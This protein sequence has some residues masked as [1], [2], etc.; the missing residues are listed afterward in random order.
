[1]KRIS[2]ICF[3]AFSF[4]LAFAGL[5]GLSQVSKKA[6]PVHA[7]DSLFW[8]GDHNL[9]ADPVANSEDGFIGEARLEQTETEYILHLSSFKNN[10]HYF[11]GGNTSMALRM[12]FLKKPVRI[13][14]AGSSILNNNS[15][16]FENAFGI[17]T[18]GDSGSAYDLIFESEDEDAPGEL[19]VN[20][21]T[22]TS[23][24]VGMSAQAQ[25]NIYFNH[26]RVEADGS[27]APK[28]TGIQTPKNIYVE[29]RARLSVYNEA[30]NAA[31][32][33]STNT[34]ISCGNFEMTSSTVYLE[35]GEARGGGMSAGMT[36]NGKFTMNSGSFTANSG[37]SEASAIGF[38]AKNDVVVN[39]GSFCAVG[40]HSGVAS[41]SYGL[42]TTDTSY[43][44]SINKGCE[45]FY[46]DSEYRASNM[47]ITSVLN[48]FGSLT[49]AVGLDPSPTKIP[50]GSASHTFMSIIFQRMTYAVECVDVDYNGKAHLPLS[51]TVS[52]PNTGYTIQ[53]RE[54]GTTA[55]HD[56]CPSFT[57]FKKGGYTI[58]Y[59]IEADYYLYSEVI[60]SVVFNI[61]K[62]NSVL[63]SAPKKVADFRA[64]GKEHALVSAGSAKGGTVMYS[65]N[66]GEYSAKVP[67]ASR[68]GKY[69]IKYK[70][71][72]DNNHNDIAEKSLGT[73]NVAMSGGAI[74][75]I[76][77]GSVV[78]AG[79]GGFALVWFVVL[80]KSW[81]ELVEGFK[82]IPGLF[83][84][85]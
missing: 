45:M 63:Q 10:N 74:A 81:G 31:N 47:E 57:N 66:G 4:S 24:S 80:K 22:A 7:T 37:S 46:L 8:I 40:G 70:V 2:K 52:D 19:S 41:S 1:M 78:V 38:W 75:G 79:I 60:D 83:K 29:N 49:T 13:K 64:N 48:G 56:E 62:V 5:L 42:K 51:I 18:F 35:A 73:V 39:G 44:A 71:V 50:A 84:K 68:A 28:V 43:K 77:I 11:D 61:N 14:L 6:E 34:G 33:D 16:G 53:Y 27:E 69:E 32:Q 12:G 85:K 15:S 59:K 36:C 21:G 54:A 25:G 72:G 26:C 17:Y 76:V 9:V 58:E 82:K 3:S 23:W 67:T 20:G 65:V 30:V 55:W